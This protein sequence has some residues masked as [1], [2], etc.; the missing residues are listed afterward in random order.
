MKKLFIPLLLVTLLF[1]ACTPKVEKGETTGEVQIVRADSL[2]VS[3]ATDVKDF[4]TDENTIYYLGE[5]NKISVDDIVNVKYHTEGKKVYA[6][7]ISIVKYAHYEKT[8]SGTV[9]DVNSYE[10][11]VNSKSTTVTFVK[12]DATKVSGKLSKGDE[13]QVTYT[14]NLSE[15]PIATEIKVTKENEEV[16]TAKVSGIV[17]E[18]SDKSLTISIDSATSY[19]FALTKD[20]KI[21]GVVKF[22]KA[23]ESVKVTYTGD[24]KKNPTAVKIDIVEETKMQFSTI[25]GS[26]KK[27][28]DKYIT[29]ATDKKEYNI[30]IDKNTKY[31]GDKPEKGCKSE[32]T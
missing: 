19:K 26:I 5:D 11:T 15:H 22:L 20:T 2:I 21:D 30:G 28:D 18:F 24:L 10:V 25:N 16:K 32:I 23:G 8:F 27:V 12:N 31:K 7:R 9:S 14:G 13:I 3:S 4:I 1:C 29:L 17:S 6:D